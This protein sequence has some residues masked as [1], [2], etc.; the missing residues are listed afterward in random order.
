[1][2]EAVVEQVSEDAD[3]AEAAAEAA[4]ES[5]RTAAEIAEKIDDATDLVVDDAAPAPYV[6]AEP[7]E[8]HPARC[9]GTPRSRSGSS[10]PSAP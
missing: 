9:C 10:V 8:P 5:A 3:R 4:E 2:L 1:M 6:P 7:T